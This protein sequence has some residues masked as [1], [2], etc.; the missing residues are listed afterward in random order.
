MSFSMVDGIAT[1]NLDSVGTLALALV[2]LLIGNYLRNHVAFLERFCIPAPVAG[3]F[4]FSFIHCV[5]YMTGVLC[6]EFDTAFQSPAMIAFFT[7]VGLATSL[8]G[9]KRGGKSFVIYYILCC[10]LI[11]AQSVLS[12]V[13]S[14]V[15][16][17]EPIYGFLA[18][19]TTMVGGHGNGGSFGQ[20]ITDL[21]YSAGLTVGMACATFGL[22]SGSLLG[23]PFADHLIK[24][25]KLDP[26]KA[27]TS[28]DEPADD[29]SEIAVEDKSNMNLM[30]HVACIAVIMTIGG[31]LVGKLSTLIKGVT[32]PAYVGGMFLG[33]IVRNVNDKTKLLKLH[34]STIDRM[35]DTFLAVFLSIA[36][37]S[38]KLWQLIDLAIPLLIILFAQVAFV[39][40]FARFIC[41]PLLGKNYDTAVMLGGLIG[42]GLGA[43]PNAIA[44]ITSVTDKYGPSKK[45]MFIVPIIAAALLDLFLLPSI[46]VTFNVALNM[47]GL[48]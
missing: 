32:L 26:S 35:Q 16:E 38:L 17:I 9:I 29:P 6:F 34:Q 48:G 11:V 2:L 4:T 19:S 30:K 27:D 28:F 37:M 12:I 45:A 7:C 39:L 13:L 33:V 47:M 8:K 31:F 20:T 23:G 25:F 1:I 14:T 36:M 42:H 44:N 15:T 21:G 3:G 5:L 40:L 41:F 18:G 24:K 43:T 22:V 46:V 10:V